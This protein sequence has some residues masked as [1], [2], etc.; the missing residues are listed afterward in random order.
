MPVRLSAYR[1]EKSVV[2]AFYPFNWQEISATQL[3]SYQAQRPRVLANNAEIGGR[4]PE[5]V[6][7]DRE[8][9][10]PEVRKLVEALEL[11][12]MRRPVGR[13]CVVR[14]GP[15]LRISIRRV[16]IVLC[17]ARLEPRIINV[18]GSACDVV[19]PGN[20]VRSRTARGD[21]IG[22]CRAFLVA[23]AVE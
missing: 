13:R 23:H 18:D 11:E 9:Q 20:G 14:E 3:V 12:M 17:C 10:L 6:V 22:R 8:Q 1:G 19:Q 4:S 16:H 2:L 15:R 5:V 7:D 21:G